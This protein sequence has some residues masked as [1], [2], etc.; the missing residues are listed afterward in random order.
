MK[1]SLLSCLMSLEKSEVATFDRKNLLKVKHHTRKEVLFS[2]GV[3]CEFLREG[4]HGKSGLSFTVAE[5][6][7]R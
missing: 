4:R 2:L 5:L 3:T 6:V 7:I 1:D